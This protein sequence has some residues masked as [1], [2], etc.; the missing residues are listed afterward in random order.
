MCEKTEVLEKQV[1]DW[2]ICLEYCVDQN[3]WDFSLNLHVKDVV[4]SFVNNGYKVVTSKSVKKLGEYL[5]CPGN[6]DSCNDFGPELGVLYNADKKEIAFVPNCWDGGV[7][8]DLSIGVSTA[9]KIGKAL[10]A[11]AKQMSKIEDKYDYEYE[12]CE[13]KAY[14]YTR[15][16][17][18]N[19]DNEDNEYEEEEDEDNE[20][21]KY[22]EDDEDD[23]D[24]ED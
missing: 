11:I 6:E 21:D 16:N 10:I 5:S 20:C 8:F 4:C 19:E 17:E 7:G 14:Y 22:Y 24:D 9:K 23:E 18:Y 3:N 15:D 13:Y 12:D 2:K 1:G